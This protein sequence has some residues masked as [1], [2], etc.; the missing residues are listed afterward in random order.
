MTTDNIFSPGAEIYELFYI[1]IGLYDFLM[2]LFVPMNLCMSNYLTS[3]C[4][5]MH[6]ITPL[7]L[8]YAATFFLFLSFLSYQQILSFGIADIPF[9]RACF[10]KMKQK[11]L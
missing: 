1:R 7:R 9:N 5:N 8:N 3:F 10:C 4:C 2:W 6:R 11:I